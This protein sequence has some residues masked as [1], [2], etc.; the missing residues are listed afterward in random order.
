VPALTLSIRDNAGWYPGAVLHTLTLAPTGSAWARCCGVH[1]YLF[2]LPD[3]LTLGPGT[4]WLAFEVG[5]SSSVYFQWLQLRPVAGE[6][7]KLSFDGGAGWRTGYGYDVPFAV[8]GRSTD[9]AQTITL[10]PVAPNPATV[11]A[12]TTLRGVASSGLPVAFSSLTPAV[13]AVGGGVVTFVGVGT[14]TVAADQ[15]GNGAYLPAPRAT[16]TV[17]VDYVF[18]GFAAPV[19]NG[20]AMNSA[21]AGQAIPLKWRLTDAAGAPVTTL[22]TAIVTVAGLACDLGGDAD[23]LEAYATSGSGLQNL[24][25]G[26]Y[27]LN[28]RSPSGYARSCKTLKLDLGEGSGPRTARFQFTK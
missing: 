23:A 25:H 7:V 5:A 9:P 21:K 27:Q 13:C 16:Q 24:G 2:T 6:S 12:T 10:F 3:P 22:T 1:D 20:G 8:L 28:W 17:A 18:Q 14:C 26:Y 11:G 15:A 19:D 4:Y